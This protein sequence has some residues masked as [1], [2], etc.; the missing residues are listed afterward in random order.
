MR[1]K[2]TKTREKADTHKK[3]RKQW[4]TYPVVFCNFLLEKK[5]ERTSCN[6]VV[7]KIYKIRVL[8]VQQ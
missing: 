8:H 2:S 5:I 1:E 7:S 6:R 3:C 4:A